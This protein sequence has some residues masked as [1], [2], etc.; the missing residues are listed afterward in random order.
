MY[1]WKSGNVCMKVRKCMY[2]RAEV[3]ESGRMLTF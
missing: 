2:E 1:V 3:Y